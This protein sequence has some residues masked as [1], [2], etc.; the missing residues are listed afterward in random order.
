[1]K[2]RGLYYLLLIFFMG[3]LS[4]LT[5]LVLHPD[6]PY[7]DREHLIVGGTTAFFTFIMV[8]FIETSILRE[9]AK[10]R[11]QI[12]SAKIGK[13]YGWPLAAIWTIIVISSLGWN[14]LLHK[15]CPVQF[16]H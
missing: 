1:M 9:Y 13:R 15:F 14:V 3:N 16:L 10:R 11:S 4:S 2:F 5:D 7:F 12:T 6:I 8:G